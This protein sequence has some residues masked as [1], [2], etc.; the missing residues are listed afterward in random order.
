M[1]SANHFRALQQPMPVN[2][3]QLS[4]DEDEELP[5]YVYESPCLFKASNEEFTPQE[6]DNFEPC[7]TDFYGGCVEEASVLDNDDSIDVQ[8]DYELYYSVGSS[9]TQT[10]AFL[11]GTMLEHISA[12]T[13]LKEC[14][15]RR[16]DVPILAHRRLPQYHDF[17]EEELLL[18][19]GVTSEPVDQVDTSVG[20]EYR[21]TRGSVCRT[22]VHGLQLD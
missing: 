18:F 21:T 11:E 16:L 17:S 15:D 10:L 14:D 22:I 7:T 20:E 12:I 2:A 5:F 3:N 19:S 6:I 8:F 13:G 1:F 9:I 4:E